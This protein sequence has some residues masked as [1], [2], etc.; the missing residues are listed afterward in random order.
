MVCPK[1]GSALE[2]GAVF[3]GNCGTRMDDG[4][5]PEAASPAGD[6]IFCPNCGKRLSADDVFCDECGC[7]LAGGKTGGLK[8]FLSSLKTSKMRFIIPACIAGALV[9]GG[10]AFAAMNLMGGKSDIPTKLVYFKDEA[11]ML[12]D[13]KKRKSK[14]VEV[15][16]SFSRNYIFTGAVSGK[17]ISKDGKYVIYRED[18]DGDTCDLFIAKISKLKDAK[19]IDTNVSSFTLLDN[20]TVLYKKKSALYYYDGKESKRLAKDVQRYGLDESQKNFYWSELDRDETTYYYQDLAQK[21]DAIKLED[22]VDSFYSEKDLKNF[23]GLKGD[24]LYR[25]DQTGNREKIATDIETI[26][27][28]NRETGMFYYTKLDT[29]SVPYGSLVYDDTGSGIE[30]RQQQRLD[31]EEFE[32][33]VQSLYLFDGKEEQLI[34]ERFSNMMA[35]SVSEA[36]QYFLFMEDPDLET[37][38][39]PWSEMQNS[40]WGSC[41][42]RAINQERMLVLASGSQKIGE[43]E[44]LDS[45][46]EAQFYPDFGK[47]YLSTQDEEDI[48]IWVASLSGNGAGT[49]TEYDE[50]EGIQLLSADENG[51]Y[52]LKDY[53]DESGDLYYN[54]KEIVRDVISAA[55]VNDNGLVAIASDYDDRDYTVT[56]TIWNGKKEIPVAEDVAYGDS[57]KDDTFVLLTNYNHNREEGDLMYFDGK[58]LR[59][60]DEDVSGFVRREE[61]GLY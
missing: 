34:S 50:G 46:S 59:K 56:L 55:T 19:R 4:P 60:L 3:C 11:M 52:Y 32:Y 27:S 53:E 21:K 23:Y 30:E 22:D 8:G 61:L 51:L 49:L 7:N 37:V 38:E 24:K 44:D 58:N 16:D 54:K 25:I 43:F 36:G 41:I 33:E 48:T 15:T 40:S 45:I 18:Y 9:V 12:V 6:V 35:V 10:G 17:Y 1:C 31:E 28:F 47:L 42:N 20:N 39:A 57:A 5:Q 13:L 29:I 14:P 2:E 26:L